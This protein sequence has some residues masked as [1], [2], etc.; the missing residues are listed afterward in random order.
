MIGMGIVKKGIH[1]LL[2]FQVNN[3]DD[4]PFAHKTRPR[5]A[6]G[7]MMIKNNIGK[8]LAEIMF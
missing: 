1:S 7:H 4:L 6:R 8:N 2:A 5:S 3:P